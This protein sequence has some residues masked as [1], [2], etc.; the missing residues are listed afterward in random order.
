MLKVVNGLGE[1]QFEHRL[2]AVRGVDPEFANRMGVLSKAY[3]VG[4]PKPGFQF[5]LFRLIRLMKTLRPHIVHTRNFGAL[6][7]IPAARIAGVPVAIHSEHGYEIET[8]SGLPL[9]R[10]LLCRAIFPMADALFAVTKDLVAYHSTQSWISA[11][12]FR[13]LYNG[14]NTDKFSPRRREANRIKRERGIPEGRTVIGSVGRL[15]PIKDHGTLLN[16]AELLVNEGVNIHVLIVGGGPELGRLQSRVEDS[17]ALRGRVTFCGAS[18][19]V[20]ELL[21]AMDVFVLC[22]VCEGMSNTILEAMASGL[23][24]VATRAGGNPE[25]VVDG[26][27]GWLFAPRDVPALVQHLKRLIDE[28]QLRQRFGTAA[29]LRA[30][31]EFDL[32]SMVK[33]YHDLYFELAARRGVLESK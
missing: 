27:C 2:C 26:Q 13:V 32:N 6:E 8:I 25:L 14:V 22:S 18:G 12:K 3:S 23:P 17:T 28:P 21:N 10:R 11:D 5:P 1:D 9:R 16:A 29:R 19:N 33:N 24:I 20:P 4:D 31:A 30:A 15:V 7:A